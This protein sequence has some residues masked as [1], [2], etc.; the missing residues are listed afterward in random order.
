[1]SRHAPVAFGV[2]MTAYSS[3]GALKCA[4]TASR[5]RSIRSVDA[6]EAGFSECGFPKQ[7][8]RIRSACAVSC[9][10]AGRP[11]PA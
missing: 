2:K 3:G 7:R 9:A 1:M 6:A 5:A 4:R 8:P 10:C 11:A